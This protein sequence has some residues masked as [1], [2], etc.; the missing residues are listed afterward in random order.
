MPRLRASNTA[1]LQMGAQPRRAAADR[2]PGQGI[3]DQPEHAD[4]KDPDENNVGARKILGVDDHV[5]EPRTRRDQLGSDQGPPTVAEPDPQTDD[6][7]RQRSRKYD[8]AQNLEALQT[9]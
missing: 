7:G 3:G 2:G 5:A 9:A 1:E 8:S 6:E 4:D